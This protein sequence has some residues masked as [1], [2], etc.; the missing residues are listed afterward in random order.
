MTGIRRTKFHR[1]RTH[2]VQNNYCRSGGISLHNLR[3]ITLYV[4]AV[5]HCISTDTTESIFTYHTLR[6]L[7]VRYSEVNISE[8]NKK[9][10]RQIKTTCLV[11]KVFMRQHIGA[12]CS[13][14]RLN[15]LSFPLAKV[16]SEENGSGQVEIW[17][18]KKFKNLTVIIIY[19]TLQLSKQW[20]NHNKK[21]KLRLKLTN[22]FLLNVNIFFYNLC[23]YFNF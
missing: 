18:H 9:K 4:C 11:E 7:S 12:Y 8:V 3:N 14:T 23:F 21:G 10:G 19:D 1:R 5:D 22:S 15:I 16:I 17:L 6:A 20:N 13:T 2:L